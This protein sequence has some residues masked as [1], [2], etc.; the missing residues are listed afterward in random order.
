MA[1]KVSRSPEGER[2]A[3]R[4]NREAASL[5]TECSCSLY[6]SLS[7][8]SPRY[9]QLL[10]VETGTPSGGCLLIA[11]TL[12]DDQSYGIGLLEAQMLE[13]AIELV[14]IDL[15]FRYLSVDRGQRLPPRIPGSG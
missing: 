4:R 11:Q 10:T 1:A 6:R 5:A 2:G 15:D 3:F 7:F 9:F 8:L 12:A 13:V 14:P